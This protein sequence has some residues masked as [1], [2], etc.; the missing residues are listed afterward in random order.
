MGQLVILKWSW[1][2]REWWDRLALPTSASQWMHPCA[3]WV[4]CPWVLRA[5]CPNQWRCPSHSQSQLTVTLTLQPRGTLQGNNSFYFQSFFSFVSSTS[6]RVQF[7]DTLSSFC[8]GFFFL[9]LNR[10]S[11]ELHCQV[12][13]QDNSGPCMEVFWKQVSIQ[14]HGEFNVGQ[15]IISTVP[16]NPPLKFINNFH[17]FGLLIR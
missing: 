1:V 2:Q 11:K 6:L 4:F 14:M 5:V 17:L 9:P 12:G 13:N 3:P 16:P 7:T 15:K 8:F 10:R